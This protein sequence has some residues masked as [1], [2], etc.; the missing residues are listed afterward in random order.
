MNFFKIFIF[1]FSLFL[2]GVLSVSGTAIGAE[3]AV[4]R[5]MR[6]FRS[7]S[8]SNTGREGVLDV[9]SKI[10][11][12]PKR[13]AE[14]FLDRALTERKA[15]ALVNAY[16]ATYFLP[17]TLDYLKEL[18]QKWILKEAG[19]SKEE[20]ELILFYGLLSKPSEA[21][22]MPQK[23]LIQKI[24]AGTVSA[25]E[26]NWV[27]TIGLN[28]FVTNNP[29][30]GDVGRIIRS[31]PGDPQKIV[32]EMPDPK[33]GKITKITADMNKINLTKKEI[34]HI[35]DGQD[36]YTYAGVPEISQIFKAYRSKRKIISMK[37]L[38]LPEN[39]PLEFETEKLGSEYTRGWLE[40]QEQIAFGKA[41]R[42]LKIP[43]HPHK[44]HIEYFALKIPL[45]INYIRNG[46]AR[47][48]VFGIEE[49]QTVLHRLSQLEQE[50]RQAIREKAVS[51]VWWL[52][53]NLNLARVISGEEILEQTE[54]DSSYLLYNNIA[55]FPVV[56]TLPTIEGMLGTATLNRAFSNRIAP[57][58]LVTKP[59]KDA[60]NL[61]SPIQF[62]KHDLGHANSTNTLDTFTYSHLS[63]RQVI[64][65]NVHIRFMETLS[66]QERKQAE[67]AYFYHTHEQ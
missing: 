57:F 46:I 17:K 52:T 20:I 60:N 21:L 55:H 54:S 50:A 65:T 35:E 6:G 19:F 34:A 63:E 32:L 41:L 61:L 39:K 2:S 59:T 64:D 45:H 27:F 13:K 9:Y 67:D 56:L 47:S 40:I 22:S 30:G 58:G 4:S 15:Q 5:C 8:I 36:H 12:E 44:T 33:I 66:G 11:Q 7:L 53:F 48:K 10:N 62:A 16:H 26:N 37:E 51:Y 18:E 31:I 24:L 38:N 1:C 49:K 23:V 3:A 28:L 43:P 29:S 25:K 14:S 42:N